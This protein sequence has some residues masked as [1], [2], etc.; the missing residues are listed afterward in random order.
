MLKNNMQQFN[1]VRKKYQQ[2]CEEYGEGLFKIKSLIKENKGLR[3][4]IKELESQ[5]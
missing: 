1:E 3:D 5:M 4:E 2:M